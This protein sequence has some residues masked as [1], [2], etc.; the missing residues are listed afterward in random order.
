M[1]V[2]TTYEPYSQDPGYIAAN[3]ALVENIDLSDVNKVADLAC[4]TGLLSQTMLKAKPSLAICGVDLDDVQV[5]IAGRHF[6]DMGATLGSL[7]EYR[8]AGAKGEN[9]VHLRVHSAMEL[10]FEDNE[11]D[12]VVMGN[13]IHLMPSKPDFLTEVARVLR[14]GGRLAFNSV[15]YVGTFPPG[16]EA[17]FGEWM[18]EAALVLAELN[19]E[20]REKGEAPIPRQRGKGGA[21]FPKAG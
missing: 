9:T 4:G 1:D 18:K 6:A 5:G 13:A 2:D 12:L 20:R 3:K 7:E 17:V 19:A 11:V 15:F 16:S 8:A 14:P 21:R 10:P